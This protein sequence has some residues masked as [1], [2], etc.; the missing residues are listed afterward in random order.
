MFN[1]E[2]KLPIRGK[3]GS[4]V[5]REMGR[6]NDVG[7]RWC[8]TKVG[9]TYRY[10]KQQPSPCIVGSLGIRIFC[11]VG[12]VLSLWKVPETLLLWWELAATSLVVS[13]FF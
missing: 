8:M 9:N 6:V 5:G 10:P 2:R 11:V 3:R 1:K 7:M 13:Q 12:D 4:D